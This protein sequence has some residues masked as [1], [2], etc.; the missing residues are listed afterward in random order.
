MLLTLLREADDDAVRQHFL[1][2]LQ[3]QG[4]DNAVKRREMRIGARI[5]AADSPEPIW[6]AA[7]ACGRRSAPNRVVLLV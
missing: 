6:G 2:Q 5:R 4:P 7:A 1:Y 3:T